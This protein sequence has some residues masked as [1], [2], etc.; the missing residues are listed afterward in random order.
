[1]DSIRVILRRNGPAD[2][3]ERQQAPALAASTVSSSAPSSAPDSPRPRQEMEERAAANPRFL[4]RLSSFSR[5][6]IPSFL[7]RRSSVAAQQ[8][9]QGGAAY[10]Q[11]APRPTSSHYSDEPLSP[12]SANFS[13]NMPH[14][15]STRLHLPNLTRTWTQ[16]SNGPPS[17][18]T[19][20][21]GEAP[22]LVPVRRPGS[23]GS[24]I[25]GPMFPELAQPRPAVHA[26]H[27]PG[28]AR[29]GSS[30]SGLSA[31]DPAEQHLADLAGTGRDRRRRR[32]RHHRNGD[33]SGGSSSSSRREGETEEEYQQR[34]E[35]RHRRRQRRRE[36]EQGQ[37]PTPKYFLFCFPWIQSKRIR[38]QI[39]K[40]FVSGIFLIML[41]TV[42]LSLSLTKNINSNEFTILLILII[43]FATI[44]FCHGLIRLCMFLIKPPQEHDE[45][46]R[47][48]EALQQRAAMSQLHN[49]GGYAVPREPIRVVLA[50]DEEAA[51]IE[52][53][54]T[55]LQPPAYGIWRESIRVDPDRI[56]WQ[57]NSEARPET[58][59]SRD[60]PEDGGAGLRG[61]GGGGSGGGTRRPPSY[62]SDDGVSY[63]VEARPR[64]IAPTAAM[65]I[66]L[67]QHPSEAG[68]LALPPS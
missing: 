58:S 50:R 55:K 42:Y 63:I 30:G 62:A 65:N 38:N 20:R 41:L 54:T 52:S 11:Y 36:Q 9:A 39:L 5:P 15:P 29:G 18:P 17:R 57:R 13:I 3:V 35:A 7:S 46:R 64:S 68:R 28:H 53:E 47:Q 56:Y 61:G 60:E 27:V 14:L 22:A 48:Q 32:R 45:E 1:M 40:C 25:G 24:M 34:R 2:D 12:K 19:T 59:S 23:A 67:P 4:H 26:A 31:A 43:L 8:N 49:P 66:P 44:F 6:A 33:S 10:A 21:Q 16:G 51:G 37:R